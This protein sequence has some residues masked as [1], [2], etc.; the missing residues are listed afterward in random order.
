M[1]FISTKYYWS[2]A[3]NLFFFVKTVFYNYEK[4]QKL[5]QRIFITG[6]LKET[7]F[8]LD[9]N[10]DAVSSFGILDGL[11]PSASV[12]IS[13]IVVA[14]TRCVVLCKTSNKLRL[15]REEKN[16]SKDDI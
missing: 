12:G 7:T 13:A 11:L 10:P 16:Q 6:T 15:Y 5:E 3:K 1:D 4:Q 2:P 9:F 14:A 8:L